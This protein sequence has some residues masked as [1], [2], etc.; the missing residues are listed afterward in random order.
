MIYL[1]TQNKQKIPNH[2]QRLTPKLVSS[3]KVIV[4]TICYK[5]KFAKLLNSYLNNNYKLVVILTNS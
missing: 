3:T 2:L 4:S 1:D 5:F